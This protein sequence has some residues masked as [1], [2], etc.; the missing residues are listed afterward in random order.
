MDCGSFGHMR[1]ASRK[2]GFAPSNSRMVT[3]QTDQLSIC[4][5]STQICSVSDAL[6]YPLPQGA[7]LD[8]FQGDS[9]ASQPLTQA[10]DD[11]FWE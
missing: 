7:P 5:L 1:S 2:N 8:S 10:A 11:D 9:G 6:T 3:N 4:C